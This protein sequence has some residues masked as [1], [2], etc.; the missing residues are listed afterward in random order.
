[1]SEALDYL[2][3]ARPEAMQAYFSFL[4]LAGKHLDPRTRAII[5]VITKVDNQTP[6]G[7]RQYLRRALK[8]GV[9]AAE[10]IDAL[11]LAFPSLGLSKIVWAVDQLLEMDLPEFRLEMQ[12]VPGAEL[13]E[14]RDLATLAELQPG[15]INCF[16]RDGRHIFVTMAGNEPIAW[17]G[18]CPHRGIRFK[19][20]NVSGDILVCPGHGHRFDL[21]T[22]Q[23]PENSSESLNRLATRTRGDKLQYQCANAATGAVDPRQEKSS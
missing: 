18:V 19:P 2:I 22:G 23:G 6:A 11:L 17:D 7:F 20:E 3:K 10:I 5:S 14:W 13:H 16:E 9:S 4:K 21:V 15:R 1:M 12:A 8:E